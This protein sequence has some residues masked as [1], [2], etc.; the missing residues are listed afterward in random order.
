MRNWDPLLSENS[1]QDDSSSRQSTRSYTRNSRSSLQP[2][3]SPCAWEKDWQDVQAVARH[4]GVPDHK[5]RLV[6]LTKEYWGKVFEPAIRVWEEGRT[7]NPDVDCNRH[8]KLGALLNYIPHHPRSFLATGH[9]ARVK[10]VPHAIRLCRAKD[11]DKDQTY[12]LSS[13]SEAQLQR[14]ICPIAEIAKPWVRRLAEYYNLPTAER[15][16]S[17]GLCF[18]GERANFGDFVAQY[19]SPPPS[20]GYLVDSEGK[21]LGEHQGLWYYTIGQGARLGGMSDPWFVARK[22]VGE[23]GQDILVVPGSDHPK[24]MCTRLHTKDFHWIH[25]RVPKGIVP[26]GK[27]RAFVQ[28]RHRMQ[29]VSG[30]LSHDWDA[31]GLTID[32]PEAI[33][34]VA[35]GQVAA[36]W[37]Q[38]WCLGSGIIEQ[39]WTADEI[40]AKSYQD[41]KRGKKEEEDLEPNGGEAAVS[42]PAQEE[43]I[44]PEATREETIGI[45]PAREQA[46]LAG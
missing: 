19:T 44:N 41:I 28:L 1:G 11:M 23:T 34:G 8:I 29:P 39:T 25:G 2:N 21:R 43:P 32:F 26:G 10:R 7:P 46:Q 27:K 9:Y 17:M 20:Q 45:R 40:P 30:V 35:P 12:Y 31:K 38:K 5:V 14:M 18:V 15:E 33:H 37:Y 16:E 24:L 3:S 42:P 6:D 13:I 22:G 36:I 4:V